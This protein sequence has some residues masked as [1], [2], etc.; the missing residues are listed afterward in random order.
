[1]NPGSR[2]SEF[3]G[4]DP[5]NVLALHRTVIVHTSQQKSSGIKTHLKT[6]SFPKTTWGHSNRYFEVNN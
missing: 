6:F 1:M 4:P 2:K 3:G 5:L